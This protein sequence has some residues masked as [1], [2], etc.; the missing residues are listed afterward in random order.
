[1]KVS[2][3]NNQPDTPR[4]VDLSVVPSDPLIATFGAAIL[5]GNI[6]AGGEM[7]AALLIPYAQIPNVMPVFEFQGGVVFEI[8]VRRVKR[9][10]LP[11]GGW[12]R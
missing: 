4:G 3:A 8:T 9:D 5:T 2:V 11:E 12:N 1:M 7:K 10:D 6:T